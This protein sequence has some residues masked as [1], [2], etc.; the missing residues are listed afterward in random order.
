MLTTVLDDVKA[1]MMAGTRHCRSH[2]PLDST[3]SFTLNHGHV[4]AERIQQV[5]EEATIATEPSGDVGEPLPAQE[6]TTSEVVEADGAESASSTLKPLVR[7]WSGKNLEVLAS[8]VAWD[9][10]GQLLD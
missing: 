7:T 6:G 10:K 1:V 4:E 9:G 2:L 8:E 3:T 5:V